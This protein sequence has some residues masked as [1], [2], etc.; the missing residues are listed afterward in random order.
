MQKLWMLLVAVV[1][2]A[3]SGCSDPLAIS[4]EAEDGTI[5]NGRTE[6]FYVLDLPEGAGPHPVIIL[7]HGSGRK[8]AQD[9]RGFAE[10]LFEHGYAT[11]RYDKRG[12]GKSG[13]TFVASNKPAVNSY[14]DLL[15][16]DMAA[17]AA[18]ASTHPLLDPD[19]IGLMGESQAGW[20]IPKAAAQ[21]E[22]AAFVVLLSGPTVP[23]E[24]VVR[25]ENLAQSKEHRK[26]STDALSDLSAHVTGGSDPWPEL[27]TLGRPGLWLFGA[28]D[29]NIPTKASVVVLDSLIEGHGQAFTYT[30]Y[31]NG[32]HGLRDASSKKGIN[33]WDDLFAWL[34]PLAQP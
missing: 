11:L 24:Q 20:V 33:Y 1:A 5:T 8:K 19:R 6:L 3:G 15:A 2:L 23:L 26:T 22:E 16:S 29:R 17:M 12:V 18:F 30:V 7:G 13:G 28:Q 9:V 10:R 21:A 25:F 4:D 14:I 27:K 31:P 32:D 34:D